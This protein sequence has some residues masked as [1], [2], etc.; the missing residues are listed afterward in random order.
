ML[1]SDEDL[2]KEGSNKWHKIIEEMTKEADY[3]KKRMQTMYTENEQ[4]R[5]KIL[6]L[7]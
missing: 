4:L 7:E 3:L 2:Q 5:S 6:L 1:G